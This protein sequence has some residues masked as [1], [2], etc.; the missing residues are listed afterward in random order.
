MKREL[1]RNEFDICIVEYLPKAPLERIGSFPP[2]EFFPLALSS[3]F[4]HW[5]NVFLEAGTVLRFIQ[6]R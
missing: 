6:V 3:I 2:L 1:A 5:G 4:F